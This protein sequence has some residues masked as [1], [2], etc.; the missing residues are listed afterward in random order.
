VAG[1]LVVDGEHQLLL[2]P[3]VQLVRL[4]LDGVLFDDVTCFDELVELLDHLVGEGKNF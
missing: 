2:V 3:L 1:T 4:L